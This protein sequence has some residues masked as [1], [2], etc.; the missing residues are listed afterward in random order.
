MSGS[1]LA[2]TAPEISYSIP[3]FIP[4]RS[5][6]EL[7]AS[8]G[9]GKTTLLYQALA[10]CANGKPFM[11][12]PVLQRPCVV[13]NY[14]NAAPAVKA[15]IERIDGA[16]RILFLETPPQLDRPEWVKLK[17]M[18]QKL[19]NPLILVDTLASA[20]V[21]SEI[22]SNGD[23]APIMK[24]LI[25]LRD[26]GATVVYLNHTLK[27]DASR[28]IG[29]QVIISQADHVC[30]LT[31]NTDGTYRLGTS[32]KSRYGFFEWHLDFN[33]ESRM[34]ELAD[35]PDQQVVEEVKRLV[36]VQA[37]VNFQGVLDAVS[38]SEKRLR[39][40]LGLYDGVHWRSETGSRNA[41]HYHPV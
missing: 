21:C 25:E 32:G 1:V 33:S 9:K 16:D 19:V 10:A 3:E 26:L 5:L 12:K 28:F 17:L 40:I 41:R 7:H 36:G 30:S 35:D 4:D 23:F 8:P 37:G 34:F 20:C 11:G 15:M 38:V 18:V 22:G 31:T 2:A 6:V 29:A 13:L 24:R 27:Q 39:A 14:E